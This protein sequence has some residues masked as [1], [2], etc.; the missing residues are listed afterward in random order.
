MADGLTGLSEGAEERPLEV[1]VREFAPGDEGA[2]RTLNESWINQHFVLEAKDRITLG[3]PRGEILEKGGRIYVV[4]RNGEVVACCALLAIDPAEF[5]VAKMAVADSCRGAG[6]GRQ[7]LQAVI[8]EARKSG[9]KRLYVET[10]RTLVP[11]V[12]LYE[13]LG[14]RHLP[15]EHVVASPYARADVY[16]EMLLQDS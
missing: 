8:G 15:P 10:N 16:M 2:F 14:F 9:V 12:R 4:V 3:D 11:A 7:L 13:S 6:I 1:T 5:E